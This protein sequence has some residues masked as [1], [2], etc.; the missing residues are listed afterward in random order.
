MVPDYPPGLKPVVNP[1]CEGVN[2]DVK[3]PGK[4]SGAKNAALTGGGNLAI[5]ANQWR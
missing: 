5:S 3:V 1:S 2:L 4:V